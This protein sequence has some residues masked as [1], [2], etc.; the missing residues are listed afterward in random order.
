MIVCLIGSAARP[1]LR[2]RGAK[3]RIELGGVVFQVAAE[4]ARSRRWT[5]GHGANDLKNEFLHNQPPGSLPLMPAGQRAIRYSM[6]A[7]TRRRSAMLGVLVLGFAG[8]ATTG[9]CGASDEPSEPGCPAPSVEPPDTPA[10]C[11]APMDDPCMRYHIPLVGNPSLDVALRNKYIAAFGSACYMSVVNTFDCFYK[12]LQAA[13]A[14]AVKIGEVAGIVPYDT[15]YTCQPD[16]VGNYTL[17]I[18]PDVASKIQINYQAAPR[19]TPLV[20]IDGVPTE[21]SGPYRNLPEL[22]DLWPGNDFYCN[23]GV[24]D[25]DGGFL[26]QRKWILQ[27]N[28]NAHKGEIRS[29][30]AGFKWPCKRQNEHCEEVVEECE[31]P[32]VLEDPDSEDP[33]FHPG[34]V[35]QVHHVVPRK[36]QRSCWW[37]TNSN[38][39]AAVI[40]AKLNQFLT[41]NNP[42][43]DEVKML[44]EAKAF[45]P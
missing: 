30:L 34:S 16:G 31:E 13:C 37:G 43:A 45:T 2:S 5:K 6:Q 23:S 36:D 14:D 42:P 35:A 12:E 21:V 27:V 39:N 18:G 24:A 33:P 1:R 17:Q 7:M 29:D 19:Q 25:A 26:T 38:K 3:A 22:K 10:G 15:G 20:E 44:N 8:A 9:A 41:N 4:R 28:R 11:A 40:S 32:D